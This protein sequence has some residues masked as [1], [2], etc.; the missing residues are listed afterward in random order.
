MTYQWFLPAL[1]MCA[2]TSMAQ[3][4]EATKTPPTYKEVAYGSH[5]RNVLY[6]WQAETQAPAPLA[7]FIHGGGFRTGSIEKLDAETLQQLLK[8]GVSVAAIHYR[9]TA[10]APFDGGARYSAGQGRRT[11]GP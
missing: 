3:T 9:L 8:G 10:D 11:R 5:E 7:L 2:G 1:A 4:E 6:F